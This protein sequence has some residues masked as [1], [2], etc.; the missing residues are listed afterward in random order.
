MPHIVGIRFKPVTKIYYFDPQGLDNLTLDDWVIVDTSRGTE[1]GRVALPMRQV[2]SSEIKAELKPVI[3]RATPV[4]LLM[5]QDFRS[6]EQEALETCRRLS[7]ELKI[8]MKV[9]QAS[10]SFDGTRLLLSFCAEQRVDFRDLVKELAKYLQTRIEMKQ[11]GDR[12]ETKIIDGYGRCGR[13]LCCSSWLTEFHPVSIRMAKQQGLPLAPPEISGVCGRLLCC[14]AYEDTMYSEIRHALPKVGS[15]LQVN[16][17]MGIVRGL[18]IIQEKVIVQFPDETMAEISMDELEEQRAGI[19]PQ[20]EAAAPKPAAKKDKKK[21]KP[22]N[23]D[24]D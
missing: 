10:Y 7:K 19:T 4:D 3:R 12:D 18:N 11:I 23:E 21:R 16:Q 8:P 2:P 1:L 6:K 15:Q 17:V 20:P 22:R 9:V 13:Q 5:A 14:L 24:E